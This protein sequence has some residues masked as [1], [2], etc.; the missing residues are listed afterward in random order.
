MAYEK[1]KDKEQKLAK[2]LGVSVQELYR[3]LWEGDWA[4]LGG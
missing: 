4:K 3:K 2:A 1:V